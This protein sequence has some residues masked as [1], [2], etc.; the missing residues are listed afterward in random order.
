MKTWEASFIPYCLQVRLH[1]FDG[2]TVDS[3]VMIRM[4]V[5]RGDDYFYKS[6]G[7]ITYRSDAQ[8]EWQELVDKV[9]VPV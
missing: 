8:Q 2:N 9:Y 4:I 3:A 5:R 1:V 7:G 6:G